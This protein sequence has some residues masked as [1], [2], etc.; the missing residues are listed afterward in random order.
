[1]PESP[2]M[3]MRSVNLPPSFPLRR[4]GKG[5]NPG[6]GCGTAGLLVT[7]VDPVSGML[8]QVGLQVMTKRPVT[9]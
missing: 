3:E 4:E 9:Y 8:A 6:S 5:R 7:S 2:K 1:M